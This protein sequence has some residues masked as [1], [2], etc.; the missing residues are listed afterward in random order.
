MTPRPTARPDA[1]AIAARPSAA[2]IG[3]RLDSPTTAPA[4]AASTAAAL[5]AATPL[6]RNRAVD[7][8]RAAA[9]GIVAVGHWLG[10][11][12]VIQGGELDGGN[13]LDW[14]PQ[15]GWATWVGQVMPL[16][17]FVGGFA[18]ATSLRSAERA[19]VRSADWVATRLRRMLAPAATLALVWVIALGAG[20]ALGGFG[21]VSMGAIA[22]AIPL[23][24]L[25]NYTIDTALAPFTFRWFRERPLV[26]VGG[27]TTLF[28]LGEAARFA[29]VPLLPQLNWV[30]GWLGFQVA[31]FAWQDGR[32]PTGRRLAALAATCWALAIAAVT[33][34]PWPAV[35][36]HHGG[37]DHSPT[38]PPSTSLMLFGLAYSFTAAAFAPAITR[39]LEHSAR[40]WR[41]TVAANAVAMSVYL[42]HM[43]AAV[44]VAAVVYLVGLVPTAAP[45]SG[46]WWSTKPWFLVL[47]VVVLI[48]IVR[49]VAPI[50]QRA[51]LAGRAQWRWGAASILVAAALLS[52]AV[53][54]WS[55]PN[56]WVLL[57]GLAATLG[58]W[59][60]LL[61]DR[62]TAITGG[63]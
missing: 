28:A 9:M 52:A 50:E 56:I 26:L 62:S 19:G 25:A 16:F 46:A 33:I 61:S 47:N 59:Q 37:L 8:Y 5:A 22:A 49:R 31:G 51:L 29:E 1:P 4:T 7:F 2:P 60:F 11:V 10:M 43:T 40:A 54:C 30:I 15:F 35:M 58:I 57:G 12:V 34:G 41:A 23:W 42:W 14:A 36:L 48:P 53:K 27:L 6:D 21:I 63:R 18:S 55:S 3:A 38:H 44:L 39:W 24:F 13:L 32:L 20:A 45:G 17:F